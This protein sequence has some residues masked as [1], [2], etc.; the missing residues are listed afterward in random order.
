M[1]SATRCSASK[2]TLGEII[3]YIA[4]DENWSDDIVILP[5]IEGSATKSDE[6]SDVSDN[7]KLLSIDHLPGMILR[8]D[9][10]VFHDIY[11]DDQCEVYE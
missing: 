5:L 9:V 2:M 10:E 1:T 3:N 4:E 7:E 11:N 6:D 8:S